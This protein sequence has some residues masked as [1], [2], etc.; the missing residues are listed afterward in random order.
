[1][2]LGE[3]PALAERYTQ[4]AIA[5][6]GFDGYPLFVPARSMAQ[7]DF[8]EVLERLADGWRG[9]KGAKSSN[10][11]KGDRGGVGKGQGALGQPG[12]IEGAPPLSTSASL[13]SS[14][15]AATA[16]TEEGARGGITNNE[17]SDNGDEEVTAGAAAGAHALASLRA[18]LG[19]VLKKRQVHQ[20]QLQVARR[21]GGVNGDGGG[22]STG[23]GG[24][25]SAM[26]MPTIPLH[27]P[28]VDVILAWLGAVH[29]PWMEASEK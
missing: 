27:G 21:G 14:T 11:G 8:G 18:L 22:P 6:D 2:L 4:S 17:A 15:S 13:S 9:A 26:I 23:A 29:L 12:L 19:P 5:I 24:S 1:M 10:G 25:R 7:A 28:R 16:K 20:L 3:F